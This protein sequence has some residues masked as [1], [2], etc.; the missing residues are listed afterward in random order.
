MVRISRA[1]NFRL[2]GLRPGLTFDTNMATEANPMKDVRETNPLDV[3]SRAPTPDL[4][5]PLPPQ[6]EIPPKRP[7]EPKLPRPDPDFPPIP[8]PAPQIQACLGR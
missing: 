6:P 7:D 8:C 3:S 2:R 1:A 4:P 5:G